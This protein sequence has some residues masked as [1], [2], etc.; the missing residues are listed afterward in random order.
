MNNLYEMNLSRYINIYIVIYV[1]D[2]MKNVYTYIMN[3]LA[4]KMYIFSYKSINTWELFK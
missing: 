3:K 2:Y 4:N 1:I